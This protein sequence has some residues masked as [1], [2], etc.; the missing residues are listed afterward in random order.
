MRV[1]TD[2]INQEK[3]RITAAQLRR[4]EVE[5][6]DKER[7]KNHYLAAYGGLSWFEEMEEAL[8]NPMFIE[9]RGWNDPVQNWVGENRI[10][11]NDFEGGKV[12]RR[13]ICASTSGCLQLH[14]RACVS[15]C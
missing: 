1:P 7:M 9:S 5:E 15:R 8:S 11:K 13:V 3:R 4:L 14:C 12:R 6:W 10:F 2:E